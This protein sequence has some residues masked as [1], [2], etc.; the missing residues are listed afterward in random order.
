MKGLGAWFFGSAIIYGILGM[1]LGNV[2]AASQDHGQI[3]THAHLMLIGWV[4]FAI[5]GFF[6]H[7][8][9]QRAATMLAKL[10]FGVAQISFLVLII[11]LYLIYD[12]NVPAGEPLAASMA[13]VY[14][15]SMVLFG[16][17]ALPVVTGRATA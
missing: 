13:I 3:A 7:Q 16:I 9:P 1:I 2:M 12:G 11:G 15:L 10:H 8:F 4:S 14:L 6:Y 5:F 17:I